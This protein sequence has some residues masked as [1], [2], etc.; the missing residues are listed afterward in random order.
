MS[1]LTLTFDNGPT[2]GVTENV[3]AA[4]AERDLRA[5]FFVVGASLSASAEA[6]DLTAEAA[7]RGHWIGNHTLGHLAPFGEWDDGAAAVDQIADMADLLGPLATSPK[8]FRPTGHG[9]IGPHLFN[10]PVVDHLCALDYTVV[11]W[12]VFVR[13]SKQP[14]G[15]ADRALAAI[16]HRPWDVLVAHDVAHGD[17][18]Q[19]P[20]LLDTVLARGITVEQ[21]F[22][23]DVLPIVDGDVNPDAAALLPLGVR[24]A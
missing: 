22:P 23:P 13:D 1:R 24:A 7:L 14:D 20:A 9:E 5:T 19:L 21:S 6:R 10:R 8:L 16:G 4:L 11:L 12:N 15:W 2:P 18:T 3:L 17:M